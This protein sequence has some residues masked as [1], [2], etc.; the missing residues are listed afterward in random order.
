M[1]A[2]PGKLGMENSMVP[3]LVFLSEG[4]ARSLFKQSKKMVKE[5]SYEFGKKATPKFSKVMEMREPF[6]NKAEKG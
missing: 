2:T 3:F 6:V 5:C 1:K 4:N